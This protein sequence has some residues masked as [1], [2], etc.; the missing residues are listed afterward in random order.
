M[1]LD[2]AQND[3]KARVRRHHVSS[4]VRTSAPAGRPRRAGSW[5][6]AG[7]ASRR[8]SAARRSPA[9]SRPWSPAR[10]RRCVPSRRHRHE[11]FGAD[12]DRVAGEAQHRRVVGAVAVGPRQVRRV[13]VKRGE[14]AHL[15]LAPA[16]GPGQSPGEP[17]GTVGL[18][19]VATTSWPRGGRRAGRRRRRAKPSPAPRRVRR[20]RA[21][22][23][24]PRR[25]TSSNGRRSRW[26][27]PVLRLHVRLV[28]PREHAGQEAFTSSRRF[29]SR[30][31][32]TSRCGRR[33][34]A[35]A[36]LLRPATRTRNGRT[37]SRRVSVPSTSKAAMSLET[38][39][40]GSYRP[41]SAPE[42]QPR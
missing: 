20:P 34:S 23:A 30:A 11:G 7:A 32:A 41:T 37:Q 13:P 8:G 42:R 27:S 29:R 39:D 12:V 26:R 2:A 35:R 5:P 22:A 21:S 9:G 10:V 33:A 19:S 28:P 3:A 15:L 6:T 24:A 38:T 25:R 31:A 14:P 17:P 16:V 1:A 40:A 36:T 18:D 4:S